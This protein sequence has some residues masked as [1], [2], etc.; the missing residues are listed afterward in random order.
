M[1]EKETREILGRIQDPEAPPIILHDSLKGLPSADFLEIEPI[2][3]K[4]VTWLNLN[5]KFFQSVYDRIRIFG[6]MAQEE[7]TD[8]DELI[9]IASEL[10]TDIDNLIIA[11]TDSVNQ[12]TKTDDEEKISITVE[13]LVMGWSRCLRRL[14]KGSS[15]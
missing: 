8:R 11:F 2:G 12:V 4:T 15:D 5:H 10:K 14:Y 1:S 7:K 9:E 6:D 3:S 13:N